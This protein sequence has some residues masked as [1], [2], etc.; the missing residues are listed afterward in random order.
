[1]ILGGLSTGSMV[2]ANS[3]VDGLGYLIP[4]LDNHRFFIGVIISALCAIV[5]LGGVKRIANVATVI[6]PFMAIAYIGMS[7]VVLLLHYEQLPKT[8]SLIFTNAFNPS[9]VFGASLW[10]VIKSGV[11][12]GLFSSEAGLGTAPIALAAMD[13]K[14]SIEAGFVGMIGPLFDTLILCTMTGLII[15]ISGAYDGSSVYTGAKLSQHAFAIGF[16]GAASY[17]GIIS[18]WVVGVSLILFAF[19]TIL[20]WSYYGDRCFSFLFGDKYVNI[21]RLS[22]LIVLVLG[23]ILKLDLVWKLADIANIG[24]AIP[25]LIAIIMLRKKIIE[26]VNEYKTQII[27]NN[28]PLWRRW[29]YSKESN[30]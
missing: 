24:M 18:T 21:Y 13:T 2:Q 1:M 16:S 7:L 15:L 27:S 20:T 10:I 8:F 14:K 23:A 5:I 9:A 11:S 25:N 19:T 29:I 6:V 3:I 22:F 30:L 17:S 4:D 28:Q 12:R 26:I